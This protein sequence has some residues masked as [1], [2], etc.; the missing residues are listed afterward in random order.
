M[1]RRFLQADAPPTTR[2]MRDIAAGLGLGDTA[3]AELEAA[4]LVHVADGGGQRRLP[5]RRLAHPPAG[6]LDGCAAVYAMCAI[7]ALG[8][9]A[10]TDAGLLTDQRN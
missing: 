4:D 8:I 6:G 1:L 5:V 10:M 3:A 2:W 7:D 9:P